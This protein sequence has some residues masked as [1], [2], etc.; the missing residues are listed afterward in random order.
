[1]TEKITIPSLAAMKQRSEKIVSLTAYDYPTARL[2]D[3]AGV[4]VLL[5]GDSV[6]M[7]VAGRPNTLEASVDEMVYHTRSVR[8]GV[9]RALLVADLPYGSYHVSEDDAIRNALR[10]IREGGAEA[11]KL[12]GG[13]KQAPLVERLVQADI[14]VMGHIGLTP[15]AI[16][17]L[18]GYRV[19]GKTPEA[20]E[21]LLDDARAL[22]AA[23]AFAI[24][25]EG[26]PREVAAWITRE[27][28]LPTIGIGAG[29]DCDAQV[30]VWQDMAGLRTGHLPRF[31]KRY[32][33]LHGV[34]SEAVRAYATD[35]RDGTFPASEHTF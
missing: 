11:V 18:G 35:V 21:H 26:M 17:L 6:S 31:V 14:P 28:P 8:R 12:E 32:A 29:P 15:Q 7:V 22:A 4:H 19:Q 5:V 13:R 33:D 2:L 10:L 23:G 27:V 1:M 25:L 30:L 24:V 20:G 16:H 3:Q 34:L 9:E